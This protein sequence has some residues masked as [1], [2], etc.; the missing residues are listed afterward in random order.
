MAFSMIC[1]GQEQSLR[2]DEIRL[3]KQQFR[4]ED[5]REALLHFLA[6]DP[7]NETILS[8]LADCCYQQGDND[9]A[10]KYYDILSGICPENILY[11]Y[12]SVAL[13]SKI[14]DYPECIAL[15]SEV[16]KNDTIP[17][18]CLLVG[19]AWQK[20]DRADS[21][22]I[23]YTRVLAKYPQNRK[24]LAKYVAILAGKHE[25][26]SAARLIRCY[27]AIHPRDVQMNAIGAKISFLKGEFLRSRDEYIFLRDS[28]YDNSYH[29]HLYL[30]LSHMELLHHKYAEEPL[31]T[32]WRIDSSDVNLALAI[33]GVLS[34]NYI[35]PEVSSRWFSKAEKMLVPDRQMLYK[36]YKNKGHMY[37]ARDIWSDGA[38]CFIKAYGLNPQDM[39]IAGLAAYCLQRAG[40]LKQAKTWYEIVLANCDKDSPDYVFARQRLTEIQ[41]ELFMVSP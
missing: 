36:I 2:I 23:W 14:Q 12:R 30:G 21:A 34:K 40:D 18:L 9:E 26:D 11:K 20:M 16:L 3:M 39:S 19:D 4:Y 24:A 29:T 7:T 41:S 37:Y 22:A 10:K 17:A 38:A 8:E 5:A 27:L 15:G 33:A 31:L 6:G 28:L 13:A 25:Y 1:W 32:A 35:D